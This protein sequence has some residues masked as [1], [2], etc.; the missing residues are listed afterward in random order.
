M[1]VLVP[2]YYY[3]IMVGNILI[4]KTCYK[5]RFRQLKTN[6]NKQCIVIIFK[7]YFKVLKYM[8]E[9]L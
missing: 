6:G 5:C 2:T 3:Q 4:F 7:E 9:T 1:Q 8:R